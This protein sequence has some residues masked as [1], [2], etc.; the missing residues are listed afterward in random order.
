MKKISNFSLLAFLFAAVIFVAA[1]TKEEEDVKLDAKLAT[2]QVLDLG[3]DSATIVGYVIAQGGGFSERGVCYDIA[4]SPTIEDNKVVYTDSANQATF[5]VIL[6]GLNYATKYYARAYAISTSGTIYGEEI[7]FT[8]LSVVPMLTTAEITLITGNSAQGGGNVTATGGAAVTAKGICFGTEQNPTIENSIT[9]DG[10]GV[11]EF[12]SELSGLNGNTTYYVRAYAKNSVGTAYGPEISFTTKVD[13]PTVE[14]TVMS[15]ITKVSAETGGNI[16]N[17]GGSAI[18]ER[19]IAYGINPDPT[20]ADNTVVDPQNAT[21]AFT[22]ILENLTKNTTYYVR[23]YATNSEGTAY[24]EEQVFTTLADLIKMWVVGDYNGWDN[25]DAAKIILSTATS[26]GDAEGYVYLT[27]GGMKLVTDHSWTD[28]FTFGDDGAGALTNPGANIPVTADG[29]Y[30]VK[31]NLSDMT[32]T[33]TLVEWGVIGAATP[34]AW[35]D[36]TPLSYDNVRDKWLGGIHLT[37]GEFK[38]RANHSWDYN[39]GSTSADENLDFNGTNMTASVEA[40]YIFELDLSVPNEYTYS[41]NHWGL[42][43]D[44]TP[45]AWDSDQDMMWDDTNKVLTITLDLVVGTMKFRANDDWPLNYG[46]DINALTLDGANIDVPE[47]GNYT[48]T[49]DPWAL[50]ATVTKN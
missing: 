34:L 17:N 29:Y 12:I 44:A 49:F 26:N 47:A 20:T 48:V 46:G 15:N 7:I 23:A 4:E 11:G 3:S 50:V 30:F 2:S 24:G 41:A 14:T 37:A 21:G 10:E 39:Y 33:L 31:A 19:G 25:S 28:P 8:T 38:F 43:G 36:E 45:N 35:D 18:T 13:L 9:E 22:A 5:N 16:S 27:T 40:D 32:Y 6:S 1:C 42:I